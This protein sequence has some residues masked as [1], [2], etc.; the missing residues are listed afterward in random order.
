[1]KRPFLT[2]TFL[3]IITICFAQIEK[4]IL[5]GNKIIGGTIS[6]SYS[7]TKYNK[8][9]INRTFSYYINPSFGYFLIDKVTIG[10]STQFYG[11][12]HK[13]FDN[14]IINTDFIGA[15]PFIKYYDK[16]GIFTSLNLS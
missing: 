8:E 14:E 3:L 9:Y 1:M 10:A 15:G 2:I 5:K 6:A 7:T 11:N 16:R 4:P 12:K 13:L